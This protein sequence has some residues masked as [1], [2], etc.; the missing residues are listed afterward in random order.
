MFSTD[1]LIVLLPPSLHSDE[2][3]T[4]TSSMAEMRNVLVLTMPNTRSYV[5]NKNL[6]DDNTVSRQKGTSSLSL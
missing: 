4:N 5:I 6:S 1:V 3:Y 2:Y